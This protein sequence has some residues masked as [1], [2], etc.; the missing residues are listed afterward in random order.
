VARIEVS[1]HVE[2]PPERVWALL[3][4]WEAQPAWMVDARSVTVLTPG[5]EGNGTILRCMT[6]IA[7]GLVVTDDMVVTEWDP[8]RTLAMRHLGRLIRG[9]GAFELEATGDGTRLT[10]W[11]EVEAPF[12]GLG[13]TVTSLAVVPSVR[14]LFR[15][16]L[17]GLKQ[18]AEAAASKP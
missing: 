12:G 18:R 8:P 9:V 14:R 7:G 4:D 10:W 13:E 5:R 1:T 3:V 17:A 6:D 11:E 16:S 15:A 2:A